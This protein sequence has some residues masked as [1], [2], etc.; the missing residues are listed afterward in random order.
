MTTQTTDGQLSTRAGRRAAA[1]GGPTAPTGDRLPVPT[2]QRRPALAALAIVLILGGAALSGFLVFSSGQK[3]S[4]LVLTRDV[5][6]GH[7]FTSGDFREAQLAFSADLRPVLVSQLPELVGSGY[8]ARQ[9]IAAG[10]VLTSGMIGTDVEIPSGGFVQA[11]VVAP[12][13]QYPV[14]GLA[15]G[16]TV[17][18][19]YTPRSAEGASA[20]G[21]KGVPLNPGV[22]V[23]K[24]AY[25]KDVQR[26]EGGE[27]TGV[28]VTLLVENSELTQGRAEGLAVLQAANALRAL[29]V[30]K[31]PESATAQTGG[32]ER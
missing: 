3:K 25:V 7:Q 19:L 17:K 4:V 13:G 18:V 6:Y 16:D 21:I 5:A 1:Q 23:I 9:P 11:G 8:R 29:S 31:L 27:D 26:I 32:G 30:Q 10:S 12:D 2:R 14:E 28:W 15:P 24:K 22:T 20:G